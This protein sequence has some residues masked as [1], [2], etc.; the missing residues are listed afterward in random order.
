MYHIHLQYLSENY[1]AKYAKLAAGRFL[2]RLGR[3]LFLSVYIQ[4]LGKSVDFVEEIT[5]GILLYIAY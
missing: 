3:F 2:T 1:Y 4:P 5:H